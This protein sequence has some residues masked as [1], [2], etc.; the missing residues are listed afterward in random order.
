[1]SSV[2]FTALSPLPPEP[3]HILLVEDD[4]LI[5]TDT[6][7]YLRDC[8]F[9]V[10]EAVN[11]EEALDLLS[12]D[13]LMRAVISD[14]RLPGERDGLALME[15]V[16]SERPQVRVMLTTGVNPMPVPPADVPLLKKPY[17]RH[18]VE[19]LVKSLLAE[20]VGATR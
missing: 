1:M 20:K 15:W 7:R 14:V 16:R 12:S 9:K 17:R 8:G 4:D 18:E 3:P 6:A 2:A 10:V 11:V 13:P 19:R 5:R